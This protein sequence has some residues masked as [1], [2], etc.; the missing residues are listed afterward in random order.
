ML[1]KSG[2]DIGEISHF[3][4]VGIL[5]C[6]LA[7]IVDH[8][9]KPADVHPPSVEQKYRRKFFRSHVDPNLSVTDPASN[10]SESHAD[11][12][13]P[14][15]A[16]IQLQHSYPALVS[17]YASM[18]IAFASFAYVL[19]FLTQ[20]WLYFSVLICAMILYGVSLVSEVGRLS[21]DTAYAAKLMMNPNFH[22]L[23]YCFTFLSMSHFQSI[24]VLFPVASCAVLA[25]M[26]RHHA[27]LQQY[28]L[29]QDLVRK[30]CTS[31]AQEQ[32]MMF[33]EYCF[34]SMSGLLVVSFFFGS[35]GLLLPIV[36]I[37]FLRIRYQVFASS[38]IAWQN[39]DLK[40][41]GL[42]PVLPQLVT[43]FYMQMRRGIIWIG[44]VERRS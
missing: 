12:P 6:P 32:V 2:R 1:Q 33:N 39:V 7:H 43:N 41:H 37:Q 38:Q 23:I 24:F 16:P 18:W 3:P 17:K 15:R 14:A 35:A 42:L 27:G 10:R 31:G 22:F 11:Q 9:T 4:Q 25:V 40:V 13:E 26:V 30:A 34:I 36:Y 19:T 28:A 29:L 21:W 8:L 20:S 5:A 44:T